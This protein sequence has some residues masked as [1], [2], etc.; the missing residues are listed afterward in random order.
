MRDRVFT[1]LG[2]EDFE[3]DFTVLEKRKLP[4]SVRSQQALYKDAWT[5]HFKTM[6]TRCL[7]TQDQL[8]VVV[9]ALGLRRERAKL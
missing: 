4:A 9:S 7:Q 8:L 1:F 3:A 2:S 5:R 6:G